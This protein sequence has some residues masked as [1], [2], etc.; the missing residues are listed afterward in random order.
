MGYPYGIEV[1]LSKTPELEERY[2]GTI[3]LNCVVDPDPAFQANLDPSN[4]DPGFDDQNM[5]KIQPKFFF[6][7]FF[8]I[9]NCN[10]HIPRPP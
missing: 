9:K 7:I 6:Y 4:P 1:P 10:L 5:T 2:R 3:L 8:L